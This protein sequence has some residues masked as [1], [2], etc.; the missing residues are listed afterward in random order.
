MPRVCLNELTGERRSM[1]TRVSAPSDWLIPTKLQP[2]LPRD[3]VISRPRL[4]AA[5]HEAL[6]TR[7]LTLVSAPAGYGKTTLLA[8]FGL[9]RAGDDQIRNRQSAIRNRLAWL[10]LDEGDNDPALFLVYLVAALQRLNPACGAATR[11]LLA[12]PS[13]SA[14]QMRRIIGALINDVLE[15]L[16]NPFALVLDD[17]HLITGPTIYFALDYLLEHLPPQ[18]HLAIATRHDPPLSLA[19]L[20]GRG[21]LAELRV[22]HL[23]FTLAETAALLNDTLRLGLPPDD[24]TAL[25]SRTEGWPVGLRLL[26][27]SLDHIPD[28][29]GRTAF[30][31]HL[32][33]TDR[34]VFDFLAD[35]VLN[36]QSQAIRDFLLETSILS[37]LTPAL[38]QAVTNRSDAG[39]ILKDLHRRNLFVV[40]LQPPVTNLQ[41]PTYRYHALFAEFLRQQLAQEMPERVTDLHRRAAQA[42]TTPARAIG[43]YLAAEMWEPAAVAIQQVGGQLLRQGLLDTLTGWI[44]ALPTPVQEAHPDLTWLLGSCA[45]LRGEFETAQSHLERVLKACEVTGDEMTEGAA[46]AELASGAFLQGDF[47]RAGELIARALAHPVPRFSLVQLL[48]G[49]AWLALFRGDWARAKADL[50]AALAVTQE[51]DD[52]HALLMLAF[53]LEPEFVALSGGL[54]CIERFCHRAQKRSAAADPLAVAIEELMTFVHLWRGRLGQAIQAGERALA[55]KDQLGGF[56]FMGVDAAAFVAVAHAARGDYAAADHFFDLLAE[57]LA[58]PLGMA[59]VV[60]VGYLYLLGRARWLQGCLEEARQVYARMCAA[61]RPDELSFAPMLRLTMQGLLEIP[62]PTPTLRRGSGRSRR[63]ATAERLLRQAAVMEQKAHLALPFG[64]ARL[65]LA[66]LYATVHRPDEALAELSPILARCEQEG[67]PGLILKEGAAV[68]PPLRL[69][70]ERGVHASFA[71]HLLDLLGA[72][73]ES[74][75]L[76]VPQT[77]ETLSV[78]EVEVLRLVAA[79]VSNRAI[80]EKLVIT[81]RTAKA[82]VSNIL[83][84]LNVSSRTQAAARAREWR[85]ID[86]L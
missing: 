48:M 6:T 71:A 76:P 19:R 45:L 1:D 43:H 39:A 21:Q 24:L 63:Y 62:V 33:H 81:E 28:A 54:E 77:G 36:R 80:A 67:T 12:H 13:D 42:Q 9:R 20:R 35:E 74:R 14:A 70:M 75:P 69:A 23:R 5:L 68:A 8:D 49:R 60:N 66:H 57:P 17:L 72:M 22:S 55:L 31:T 41:P 50:Q 53:Y 84:K 15:T 52:P 18:M 46:L 79:G 73:G 38:C 29:A 78:R 61:A 34:Y 4:L 86:E 85:L 10:T 65:M 40:N 7:R 11:S 58:Q 2:P 44:R 56:P 47:S 82:H 26:A 59:E 32:A 64:S 16:P 51:A 25:Q 83:R 37:D 30:I 3:D 27:D